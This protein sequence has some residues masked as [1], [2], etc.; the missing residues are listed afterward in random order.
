M[1]MLT[2]KSIEIDIGIKALL[3]ATSHHTAI[4]RF[5]LPRTQPG[6]AKNLVPISFSLVKELVIYDFS[7]QGFQIK[8]VSCQGGIR[9]PEPVLFPIHSHYA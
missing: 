2:D 6:R 4:D 9:D 7:H 5:A 8:T 3:T 1:T